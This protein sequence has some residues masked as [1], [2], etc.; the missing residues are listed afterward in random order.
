M[1]TYTLAIKILQY[2]IDI[3]ALHHFVQI[4]WYKRSRVLHDLVRKKYFVQIFSP[5]R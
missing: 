5:N 1:W 2:G 3:L 4:E